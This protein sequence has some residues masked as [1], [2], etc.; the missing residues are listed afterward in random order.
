MKCH[1]CHNLIER[2]HKFCPHCGQKKR[3]VNPSIGISL[4]LASLLFITLY[5]GVPFPQELVSFETDTLSDDEST[6]LIEDQN[7]V[8]LV[9]AVQKTVYTVYTKYNQGSAFLYD[10]TG[11]V[12]TNAHVVEG[13]LTPTIKTS[14]GNEYRGTVIGYSNEIDVAVISVPE[15]KG[16]VPFALEKETESDI[17]VEV[18]ALG[19]PLGRE[20]SAT[21]GYLTG[22]NRTFHIPP[23]TFTNVYQ[24]SAPIEPGNSGGPLVSIDAEK[25]IGM[26]AAKNIDAENIAYSIPL[27]QIV[28]LIDE[29]IETP[30]SEQEITA[31][32]YD[33]EGNYYYDLLWALLEDYY[34]DDGYYL[35]D[36]D[37]HHYWLYDDDAHL[38]EQYYDDD[39][40][41]NQWDEDDWYKD[42]YEWET[43]EYWDDEFYWDEG[44]WDFDYWDDEYENDWDEGDDDW[45]SSDEYKD[46]D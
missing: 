33:E 22:T 10:E 41:F 21:F 2:R 31:L 11:S 18:I 15:L 8:E 37:Y 13:S 29:W 27:H 39:P 12:I 7:K 1:Q 3:V 17:G 28:P 6:T 25:I 19:T 42:Y 5:F 43:D 40:Y 30:L 16:S 46:Y 24:I 36:E 9:E 38:W 34:F 23:H 44:D 20:N 45:G 35:D 4:I 14:D 32:F 26:N